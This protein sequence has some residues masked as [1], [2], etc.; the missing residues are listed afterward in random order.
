[1]NRKTILLIF[2]ALSLIN[3]GKTTEKA[4]SLDS[5]TLIAGVNNN[6]EIDSLK[7]F[8]IDDESEDK[9]KTYEI[10]GNNIFLRSG[11]GSNYKKLV[12]EKATE[13]LGEINYMQVDYSCV[14]SIDDEKNG[15]AKIR[16]IDPPHLYDSHIGWIPL[17]NIIKENRPNVN[18]DY[19]KFKYEV[20]STSENN[21]SKNY[22]LYLDTK[23]FSK[24]EII[25]FIKQFREKNCNS[26]TINI[27]DVKSIKNLVNKYPLS[28]NEYLYFADH[29][30]ASSSFDAPKVVAF[31]PY[32]DS[33]YEDYGGKNYKEHKMK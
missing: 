26:C 28:K 7:M 6:N 16:V 25:N 10:K 18:V 27:Y 24:D 8:G 32:Q 12:N 23:N 2:G 3:C 19:A 30:V 21:I 5:D 17:S 22:Q 1:M 11:P 31:Y 20:I 13:A 14:V 15:W 29:F 4:T 33:K 9:N